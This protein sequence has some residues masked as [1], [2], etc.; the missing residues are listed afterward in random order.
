MAIL[1][2]EYGIQLKFP[3]RKCEDCMWYPC[4][5]NFHI[6]NSPFAVYG[7]KEYKLKQNE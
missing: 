4:M 6:F 3:D 2:D 5:A 7:C 1:K